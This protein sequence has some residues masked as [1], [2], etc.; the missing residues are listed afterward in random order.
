MAQNVLFI[1][2]DQHQRD[3]TGC[4]GDPLVKT[5]NLD[6][7]AARGTTFDKAYC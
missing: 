2:S 5:P 1:C 4:Y 7:L 3:I 6:R